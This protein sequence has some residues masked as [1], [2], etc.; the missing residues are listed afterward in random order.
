MQERGNALRH[1][2]ASFHD[3]Y[4]AQWAPHGGAAFFDGQRLPHPGG[5]LLSSRRDPRPFPFDGHVLSRGR[6]G[7][8]TCLFDPGP[9]P[10]CPRTASALANVS[11][12]ERL[13]EYAE[14]IGI[15]FE[16]LRQCRA[17]SAAY[18]NGARGTICPWT[19]HMRLMGQPDRA[20]L[21]QRQLTLR[22]EKGRAPGLAKR[23]R[24]F[25]RVGAALQGL[26]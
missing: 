5:A 9:L 8:R 7:R 26:V 23:D 24:P 20:E 6:W 18:P 25:G 21:V 1:G 16:T 4:R 19:V 10:A 11:S 2:W 13:A 17:V 3:D 15:A 14:T 22:I 12:L